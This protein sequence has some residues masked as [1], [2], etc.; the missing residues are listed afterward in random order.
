MLKKITLVV[1]LLAT[2]GIVNA[3]SNYSKAIGARVSP[4]SNYDAFAASFKTFV[5]EA[6]AVELNAGF[7]TN[8]VPGWG[9]YNKFSTT[10]LSISGA[11]QHHFPIKPV[12]GLQWY[13]GGGASIV[14]TFSDYSE[15]KGVS[16]GLFP[17][18]GVDYK[19]KSIPLNVSADYRPTFFVAKPDEGWSRFSGEQFGVSARYTF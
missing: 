10:S 6:G 14:N 8:R 11:Y 4:L 13:V 2:F 12:E 7:G 17:T 1:A 3:Q 18:G 19:F 9:A 15:F 5:T 16:A